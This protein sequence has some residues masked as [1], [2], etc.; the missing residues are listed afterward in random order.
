MSAKPFVQAGGQTDD[1]NIDLPRS[2]KPDF[3]APRVVLKNCGTMVMLNP[4]GLMPR[5][6][7]QALG[8]FADDTRGLRELDLRIGGQMPVFV[9]GGAQSNFDASFFY[10]STALSGIGASASAGAGAVKVRSDLVIHADDLFCQLTLTSE[11]DAVVQFDFEVSFA[12]G[13][14]D[15]FEV[16]GSERKEHGVFLEPR[17]VNA[18]TVVLAYLGLDD[19]HR[20]V[21]VEFGG[22]TPAIFSG[23]RATFNIVLRPGECWEVGMRVSYKSGDRSHDSVV[24]DWNFARALDYARADFD[25]WMRC[26][27]SVETSNPTLN[28]VLRRA[29]EDINMLRLGRLG[30]AAGL[31]QFAVPFGRDS[32][33]TGLQTCWLMPE[34]SRSIILALGSYQG[35]KYDAVT[36]E[37]PGKIMHELRTGEMVKTGEAPFG[38]Y[39]GTVDATQLWLMLIVEYVKWTGDSVLLADFWPQIEAAVDFLCRRARR[40]GFITYGGRPG[41]ALA[42]QCWKD[43]FNSIMY[44]DGKLAVAPIAVCEAQGYMYAAFAGVAK[45]ARTLG[46]SSYAVRLEARAEKLRH[47]FQRRFWM[48]EKGF[49]A[50]ALDKHRRQCDVISSN[51]GHLIGIGILTPRQEE[52]VAKRLMQPDM[53]NGWFIRTL[54]SSE[55]AYDASDY[56]RGSGWPHDNGWAAAG[57]RAVGCYEDA[58]KV[59]AAH[60]DIASAADDFRLHELYCGDARTADSTEPV[61]YK[62]ACV[63]QA[64][65]AGSI[66]YMLGACINP[67][68]VN[69]ALSVCNPRLPEWLQSVT[70]SRL[71]V[72]DAEVTLRFDR[73][74]AGKTTCA[75]MRNDRNC[76][77][78]VM[79][80]NKMRRVRLL[81]TA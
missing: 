2:G 39:Y 55:I 66:L 58:I 21:L 20:S 54:A 1:Y 69:G 18:Q 52:L 67:E 72:G 22:Q 8:M 10:E 40:T 13:F 25:H 77:V 65:A 27:A 70:V 46:K 64:W 50:L 75:I 14:E 48:A 7:D 37:E 41:E 61:P 57:M 42:N 80:N 11:A 34:L 32:A 3:T 9:S 74:K 35:T 73:S 29:V 44:S 26:N 56:Q 49:V 12:A 31:P 23:D 62:V 28:K 51:P 6:P 19:V 5:S 43:S 4:Q 16:R 47:D 81:R 79:R 30:I 38:P 63:P 59:F 71:R 78:K 53:F 60:V 33:I 76:K 17:K 68:P 24:P 15:V 36:A 45:L